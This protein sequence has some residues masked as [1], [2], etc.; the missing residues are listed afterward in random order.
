MAQEEIFAGQLFEL[1]ANTGKQ[2]GP[3]GSN[4]KIK[5]RRPDG[6]TGTWNAAFYNAG[7]PATTQIVYQL[8]APDTAGFPGTWQFQAYAEISGRAQYGKVKA[9]T[10]KRPLE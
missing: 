3:S 7:G 10:L 1:R 6:Q 8:S 4:P 5:Y 9:L 2:I